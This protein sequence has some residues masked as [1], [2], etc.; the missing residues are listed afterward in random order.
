MGPF[1]RKGKVVPDTF[2]IGLS[3]RATILPA[4]AREVTRI[5]C[6]GPHIVTSRPI[7]AG[8]SFGTV[9]LQLRPDAATG[10]G[11]TFEIGGLKATGYDAANDQDANVTF[12]PTAP[13]RQVGKAIHWDLPADM[14]TPLLCEASYNCVPAVG[15]QFALGGGFV[16]SYGA[17]STTLA[18]LALSSQDFNGRPRPLV[19]GTLDGA[20][21]T[22][23]SGTDTTSEF[24]DRVGAALGLSSLRT[25]TTGV[26]VHFTNTA[27][28]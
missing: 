20:P 15:A 3:G 6:R 27:P 14:H 22:V 9:Q 5:R 28:P 13:A 10:I 1:Q 7:R 23:I 19:T 18:D 21:I 4:L 26:F 2:E 24:D 8:S 12:T 16:L 25:G 17:R 11:G